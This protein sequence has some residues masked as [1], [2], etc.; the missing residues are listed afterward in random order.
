MLAPPNPSMCV[1][2]VT[3]GKLTKIHLLTDMG[4]HCARCNELEKT[5]GG[6][7]LDQTKTNQSSTVVVVSDGQTNPGHP[8][9]ACQPD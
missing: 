2:E 7:A 3:S 1:T 8:Q 6:P 5:T 4:A 9:Q